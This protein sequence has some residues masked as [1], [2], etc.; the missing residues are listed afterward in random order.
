MTAIDATGAWPVVLTPF[1]DADEVDLEALDWYVDWLIDRGAG[2]LFAVALSGEMYELTAQ[3]RIAVAGRVASR[4]AGRVPVAAAVVGAGTAA[5]MTQE[6]RALAA[7]GVDIVV[8]IAST[9]LSEA[10]DEQV[11]LAVADQVAAAVPDIALGVYECPLPYHRLLTEETVAVLAGTGRFVF[12]KE[13]SHDVAR[14]SRR[15]ADAAGTPLR[16]FNAG[17]ENYAES[18]QHGVSGL[19]GWIVNVAPDLV[20]RL[21]RLAAAEGLTER[22]LVLQQVL[23]TVEER[24]G[25]TYPSSAK[26]IVQ[27]RAG[28]GWAARSRWRPAEVDHGLVDELAA[29][30]DAEFVT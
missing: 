25:P 5:S 23:R 14:M 30:L 27:R 9:V 10:D 16:V 7:A 13:T 24:M 21:G 29:A 3:E 1:T 17:I 15:V 20:D 2:G 4:C 11:F 28:I 18:V 19:S 26:A 6:A 22:V 12:F 8:L